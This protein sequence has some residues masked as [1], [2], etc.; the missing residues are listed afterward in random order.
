MGGQFENAIHAC[1]ASLE[2]EKKIHIQIARKGKKIVVQCRNTCVKDIR[3]KNGVPVSDRGIGI[4][5]V[6][7]VV[8]FYHGEAEFSVES[9]MFIARILLN[10]P[11][12][13]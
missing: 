1:M 4:S 9:G 5:S 7:K 8:S 13:Q 3:L 11:Q 10:L 2:P 6:L 12:D